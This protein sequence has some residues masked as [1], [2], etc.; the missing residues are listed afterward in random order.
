MKVVFLLFDSLNRATLGAYGGT[1]IPTPNFDR[2][3]ER[4]VRFE[5]HFVGSMP[6]MPARRDMHTGRLNFLHR[7]WGPLEPFDKSFVSMLRQAGVWTHLVS[8]HFH[9]FTEGGSTYHTQYSSWEFIRGQEAD[10]WK[11]MV[12]PPVERFREM[13]HRVQT[14]LSDDRYLPYM[15]NREFIREEADFPLVKCIEGGL[16]FLEQN[17]DKND[18]FL[19]IE[20]FDPH[21]P[22]FAPPRF[23]RPFPSG[24]EGPILDWPRYERVS[25]NAEEITELRANYAALVTMCDEYFGKVLDYF[26]TNRMWDDTVLIVSTDH[27]YL[28]GEHDWWAKNRMPFYNEIANI[29]LFICH[30]D[31]K[32]QGGSR[33]KA[34]TQ[35]MDIMPTI[36]ELFGQPV[37]DSAE[38]LSLQK[39]LGADRAHHQAVLYGIF[40]G[41]T[42]I[43]DGRYTYFRYPR[44]VFSQEI[45]EYTLMPTHQRSHFTAETLRGSELSRGFGFSD[46]VPMLRIPA[47][48]APDGRIAGQGLIEDTETVLYD[49]EI[50]PGQTMPIE[51]PEVVDRLETEMVRLMRRNEAPREAFSRLGLAA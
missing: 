10:R 29:P 23:R 9:Y 51:A 1:H 24:Y 11:A 44:D 18:W 34:L 38:G 32:A 36:L 47:R 5:N 16:Q 22:F 46:G 7:S 31:H 40:G 14:D 42:N 39:L 28:L 2:L 25:E 49:T 41:S 37:P 33:R 20:C 3:A 43:T 15:I 50:D 4:A 30:P 45:Y 21:E 17:R 6:C 26:D 12:Q 48:R 19:Q 8:D 13:Y 27:G 35:T